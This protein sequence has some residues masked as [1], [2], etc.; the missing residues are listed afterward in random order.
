MRWREKGILALALILALV[1]RWWLAGSP[2]CI[3]TDGV[4]F[5]ELARQM[6]EGGGWFHPS[7]AITP[8]YSRL[9][10]TL[11]GLFGGSLEQLARYLSAACGALALAPAWLGWR[12][13][14]GEEAAGL[15]CLLAAAW[16]MSVELGS[17][18]YYETLSLV[19]L[20]G[21]WCAWLLAERGQRSGG[22]G[23]VSGLC[24]GGVAWMKPEVLA[25]SAAGACLLGWRRKWL[26]ALLL[27]GVTALL[28]FPYVLM[29]HQH[30]G[31]WRIAAKQ[32]VNVL[33]A[34]AVGQ[35]DYHRAVEELREAGA[36][37]ETAGVWPDLFEMGRR[38]LINVYLVHRYALP[39]T[40]PG[41]LT[42]L[43]AVG[44][45]LAWRQRLPGFWLCLPGLAIAPLLFFQIE[46][47]VW[48]ALFFV[49]AGLGGLALAQAQGWRRWALVGLCLF[50]LVPEAL[51]PLYREHE[52]EAE[53]RAGLWLWQHAQKEDVVLDRK[54]LVAYYADLP[55]I[56]PVAR[57]GLEGL[58][59]VLTPHKSAVLVV[60][61]RY[62]RRSRPEW[63]ELLQCPPPW[64]EER[65]RFIGPEGHVVRLLAWRGDW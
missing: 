31:Q 9:L 38:A 45:F 27:A 7:V 21:G 62:F 24:W 22:L 57:L 53:R 16:P 36:R 11:H 55:R 63:F 15:A 58:K 56:W 49:L 54:P 52:D 14:L 29:V 44:L 51:R 64:L 40:W 20:L 42:G 6:S 4:F 37:D 5:L 41:L 59:E 2:R 1:L 39:Q 61:N 47:R 50:F 13:V 35:E 46:A 17:G 65:A 19:G 8:G 23:V 60:D 33:L 10:A 28:Y 48:H 43:V 32:D 25:W 26:A 3:T 12:L 18:V 30:T 34:Q